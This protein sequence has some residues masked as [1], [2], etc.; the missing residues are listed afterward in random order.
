MMSIQ[1][2]LTRTL[3]IV[4]PSLTAISGFVIYFS[5]RARLIAEFNQ[6]LITQTRAIGDSVMREGTGEL[7]FYFA[8]SDRPEFRKGDRSNYFE[9]WNADGSVFRKSASVRVIPHLDLDDIPP[10]AGRA[11]VA[12]GSLYLLVASDANSLNKTLGTIWSALFWSGLALMTSIVGVVAFVVRGGLAPIRKLA[13]EADA[14]GADSLHQRLSQ[15][16]LPEEL[17]PLS[18][19]FN[20]LLGRLE[21][22]FIRERGFA[23]AAA[24]ELRTPIAELRSLA[25]VALRWPDEA[26]AQRGFKDSLQIAQ[27]MESLVG[28]LLAIV[29]T[30]AKS[31]PMRESDVDL[32][33]LLP[34]L[35]QHFEAGAIDRRIAFSFIA[36][37]NSVARTDALIVGALFENLLSN[38]AAHT[39]VGGNVECRIEQDGGLL[40]ISLSNTCRD[41]SVDDLPRLFDPF[42]RKDESRTGGQH[43]GLGLSLV[44]TYAT[45][46]NL[47]V[48]VQLQPPDTFKVTVGPMAVSS[49]I[50]AEV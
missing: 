43:F 34:Q 3:I 2:R 35:W 47:S 27:R 48:R 11:P 1:Q 4:V 26:D 49:K 32:N 21:A 9:L 45:A 19:K 8:D 6:A 25:E 36:A 41:L 12:N 39:P 38:A 31:I 28:A 40:Q 24:H 42:W 44:A 17:I 46:L 15:D 16:S 29:R 30:D 20:E 7:E 22:A 13:A 10:S 23:S 14:I 50:T 5:C 18:R 37:A 33:A